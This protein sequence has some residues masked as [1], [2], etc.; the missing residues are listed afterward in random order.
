MFVF[1][2]SCGMFIVAVILFDCG[3][4]GCYLSAWFGVFTLGS[5][6]V[7]ISDCLFIAVWLIILWVVFQVDCLCFR[8]ACGDLFVLWVL[9]CVGWF[10]F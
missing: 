10:G 3:L 9:V 7:V 6:V 5:L 2:V 8:L 4:Q 1:V